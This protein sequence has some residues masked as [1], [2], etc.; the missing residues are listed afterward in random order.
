MGEW[1]SMGEKCEEMGGC[2][3]GG[4]GACCGESSEQC[5]CGGK[6]ACCA[7]EQ[8]EEEMDMGAM[9]LC[10]ADEARM[11]VMRRKM[12]ALIEKE[13]GAKMD[14]IAKLVVE[15]YVKMWKMKMEN[16]GMVASEVQAFNDSLEK[17]MTE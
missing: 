13:N 12:E 3:C 16:K 11:N 15:H 14:K 6:G 8:C 17:A 2:G 7:E 4:N 10:L 5:A 1:F 9:L